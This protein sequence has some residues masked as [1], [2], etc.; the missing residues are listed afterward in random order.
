M[1]IHTCTVLTLKDRDRL[2][3]PSERFLD[4][5]FTTAWNC[6]LDHQN[7]EGGHDPSVELGNVSKTSKEKA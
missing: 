6:I 1:G 5:L 2:N 4:G 7:K 3:L